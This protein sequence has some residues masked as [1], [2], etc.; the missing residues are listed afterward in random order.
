MTIQIGDPVLCGVPSG[1]ILGAA[2]YDI[3]SAAS[4]FAEV[5]IGNVTDHLKITIAGNVPTLY[6]VGG[7][8]R[9]GDAGASSGATQHSLNSADDLMVTG[10]LEVGLT[11]YPNA[12]T[13]GGTVTLNGQVFDAGSGDALITTTGAY[14]GLI[15]RATL[16]GAQGIRIRGEVISADPAADDVIIDIAAYAQDLGVDGVVPYGTYRILIEAPTDGSQEGKHEWHTRIDGSDNLAMTLSSA[17]ELTLDKQVTFDQDVDSGAV[18]D[19]VSLGGF[20]MGVD[21]RALAISQ[22]CAVA[23]ETD[24]TKFSHKMPVRINGT[25]Y[26]MMLTAT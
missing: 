12:Q 4:P 11:F 3:G 9:I 20:D 21:E 17:G 19:Q 22:E 18:A 14:K 8:L 2:T 16:D 10:D 13:L 1:D 6:G 15:L 5:H 23:V 25:T 24:E 7:F 26:F